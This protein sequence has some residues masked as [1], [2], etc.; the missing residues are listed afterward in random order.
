MHAV[1]A[2][3]HKRSHSSPGDRVMTLH[4]GACSVYYVVMGDKVQGP[5]SIVLDGTTADGG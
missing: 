2:L 1:A 3:Q 5:H 4:F